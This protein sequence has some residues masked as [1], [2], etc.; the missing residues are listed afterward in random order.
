MVG[1]K[2]PSLPI[3][4]SLLQGLLGFMSGPLHKGEVS[5]WAVIIS[6]MGHLT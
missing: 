3:P 4:S 5:L 6:R 2:D 1:R